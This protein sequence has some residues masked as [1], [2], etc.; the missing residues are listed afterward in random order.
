M[1]APASR[2]FFIVPLR[3]FFWIVRCFGIVCQPPGGAWSLEA[4]C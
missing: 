4:F 1:A 2:V 3:L